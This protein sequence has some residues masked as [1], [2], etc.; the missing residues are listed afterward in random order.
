M[1]RAASSLPVPVSPWIR[2][3]ASQAE[4]LR[5]S[6]TASRNAL[7]APTR[8][9]RASS[10]AGERGPSAAEAR[11]EPRAGPAPRAVSLSMQ[12]R[13]GRRAAARRFAPRPPI[14]Q[15]VP[16]VEEETSHPGTTGAL[17]A[18]SALGERGVSV[19]S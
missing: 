13:G 8:L 5:M 17:R 10:P 3:V 9:V 7:D 4:I 12:E 11:D 1:A 2:T 6:S 18:D 15:G 16:Y 19:S 14:R